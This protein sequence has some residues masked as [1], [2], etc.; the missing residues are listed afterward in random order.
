ML[1]KE[2][3]SLPSGEVC[4]QRCKLE[5]KQ[6]RSKKVEEAFLR[7]LD[8]VERMRKCDAEYKGFFAGISGEY[9]E[10]GASGALTRGKIE[11]LPTGRNFYAVDPTT[12]PTPAA[13]KVGIET[14]EKLIKYYLE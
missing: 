1:S 6:D 3:W 5:Y 11:I 4:M 14:A 7:A 13:W 9:V 12:L 8:I 2:N 10:P